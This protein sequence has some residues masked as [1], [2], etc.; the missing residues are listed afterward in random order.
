MMEFEKL[1]Q[2]LIDNIYAPA[3]GGRF[4]TTGHQKQRESASAI[5]LMR[6]LTVYFSESSITKA[7]GQAYGE[8][9]HDVAFK[10]ELAVVADA[11]VDLSVLNDD[12]ATASAKATALRQMLE[13][14]AVADTEMDEFIRI[15]FQITMD[16][17][18]DQMGLVPSDDRLKL[19][20]V[21][22]RWV[23]QIRKDTPVPE[24]ESMMLTASMRLTCRVVEQI[25]GDDLGEFGGKTFNGSLELSGDDISKQGVEVTTS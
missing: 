1:K 19:K 13:A 5:S 15:I 23:D 25:T 2:S 12:S 6:Q 20:R 21:S 24:G 8:V 3:E 17:A 9:M 18:N 14:G 7:A 16:A 10:L 11:K 4:V 22:D